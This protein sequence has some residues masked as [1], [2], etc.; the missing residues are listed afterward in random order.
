MTFNLTRA[1]DDTSILYWIPEALR[2]PF[3]F[4]V[5]GGALVLST[6]Y[7]LRARQRGIATFCGLLAA[8]LAVSFAASPA[9]H[10]NYLLWY[11]PFIAVAI[12]AKLWQVPRVPVSGPAELV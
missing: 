7:A 11:F 5:L 2:I 10:G 8:T 1:V 3:T 9:V 12:A 6:K 4:L